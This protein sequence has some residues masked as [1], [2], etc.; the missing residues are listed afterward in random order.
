[1]LKTIKY[2]KRCQR[3]LDKR[4]SPGRRWWQL[5]WVD[6]SGINLSCCIAPVATGHTAVRAA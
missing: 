4:C 1:M 5:V 6:V 3:R 2:L